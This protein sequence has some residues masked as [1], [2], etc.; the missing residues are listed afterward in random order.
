M[1]YGLDL[2]YSCWLFLLFSLVVDPLSYESHVVFGIYPNLGRE[3]LHWFPEEVFM[4]GNMWNLGCMRVVIQLWCL[5]GNL[6]R[7][8]IIVWK[9]SWVLE[10][11]FHCLLA[12]PVL[13]RCLVPFWLLLVWTKLIFLSKAFGIFLHVISFWFEQ[14]WFFSLKLLG[15]FFMSFLHVM[16]LQGGGS[17]FGMC[18]FSYMFCA[19]N[20]PFQP[21][22]SSPVVLG[23]FIDIFEF[24]WPFVFLCFLFQ[25]FFFLF[26]CWASWTSPLISFLSSPLF[27][28]IVSFSAFLR[29]LQLS[30]SF[31]VNL[32]FLMSCSSFSR[33]PFCFENFFY[34]CD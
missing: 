8:G 13:V 22:N 14:N 28:F 17:W 19:L 24:F 27:Y 33:A 26:R 23:H 16:K 11:L 31:S 20:G 34:L 10:A 25:F 12:S 7:Y 18:L 6:A 2:L 32:V 21:G 30:V 4:R 9:L 29:F 1:L 3:I 5:N 15:S